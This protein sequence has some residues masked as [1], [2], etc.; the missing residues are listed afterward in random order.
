MKKV[1]QWILFAS[2]AILMAGCAHLEPEVEYLITEYP[3]PDK[4]GIYHKVSQGE[5]IWRIAKTYD[6]SMQDIIRSNNIPN[7]AQVEENQL[8]FI[9]G[10]AAVREIIVESE[11]EQKDFVWPLK[12]RIINYFN[13]YSESSFSKGIDIRAAEGDTVQAARTGQVV[14]ADYLSGYGYTVI[15]DHK[16]GFH[17][18]Y[19][20]N[21]KLLVKLGDHVF[22]KTPIARIGAMRNL[23]YLHFQVRKD[24]VE[25]NPLFYLP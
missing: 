11:D 3:A 16:D 13:E 21:A 6:I 19:A 8:I 23:A 12:G 25:D 5:T 10:A 15:L 18:V 22:K 2:F 7:V 9:P 1:F 24:S 17:T 20:R 14:F 4:I